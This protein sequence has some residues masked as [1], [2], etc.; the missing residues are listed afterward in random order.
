MPSRRNA[1]A[2]E[3]ASSTGSFAANAPEQ[4]AGG[5]LHGRRDEAAHERRRCS[6]LRE[7]VHGGDAGAAGGLD[8]DA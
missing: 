8:G 6:R 7:D 1:G 2:S 5:R 3:S 4:R